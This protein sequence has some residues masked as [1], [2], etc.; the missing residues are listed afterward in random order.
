MRVEYLL[1][2]AQ[3]GAHNK[4]LRI[5]LFIVC[6]H[7]K[8][9]ERRDVGGHSRM[10]KGNQRRSWT[11]VPEAYAQSR[12]QASPSRRGKSLMPLRR[13]RFGDPL[14]RGCGQIMELPTGTRRA[15]PLLW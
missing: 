5:F 1:R 12:A 3:I 4:K 8:I 14:P 15:C 10:L 6:L 9:L 11:Q 13:A 2:G 7:R